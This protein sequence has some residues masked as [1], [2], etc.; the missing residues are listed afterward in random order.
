MDQK[1]S[2]KC[3][4]GPA[5]TSFYVNTAIGQR[6]LFDKCVG[7][8]LKI[9]YFTVCVPPQVCLDIKKNWCPDP[10]GFGIVLLRC[11][12]NID[13][14]SIYRIVSYRIVSP[15]EV[16]KF[17]TNRYH[18]FSYHLAEFLLIHLFI[19]ASLNYS[20]KQ[21]MMKTL[22]HI[23]VQQSKHKIGLIRSVNFRYQRSVVAPRLQF[24][25]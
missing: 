14:I 15:A 8:R 21:I 23:F 20:N 10:K 4:A 25:N 24:I 19:L 17:S 18:I 3:L 1:R 11:I 5:S 2:T 12:E 22:I 7:V 9:Y 6:L 16:S 13:S